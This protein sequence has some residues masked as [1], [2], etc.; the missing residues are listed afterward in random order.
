M[1]DTFTGHEH[2][3]GRVI[4]VDEV[5]AR[6]AAITSCQYALDSGEDPHTVA[7]ELLD[8]L[9]LHEAEK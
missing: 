1:L 6:A 2:S 4:G 7:A 9:G 8:A 3:I 5:A